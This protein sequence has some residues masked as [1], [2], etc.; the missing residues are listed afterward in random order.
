[1]CV[2]VRVYA[3]VC[4]YVFVGRGGGGEQRVG[5]LEDV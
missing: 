3:C 1:M 4:T 5:W 2:Y